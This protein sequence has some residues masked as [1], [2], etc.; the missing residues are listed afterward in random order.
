MNLIYIKLK[1]LFSNEQLK[2]LRH[3]K[4]IIINLPKNIK[5][6]TLRLFLRNTQI[7]DLN[8]FEQTIY[9]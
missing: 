2:N 8:L 5:G 1:S 3:F 7:R 6:D 4:K 9:S